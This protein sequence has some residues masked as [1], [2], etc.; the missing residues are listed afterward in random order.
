[1]APESSVPEA[2]RYSTFCIQKVSNTNEVPGVSLADLSDFCAMI[3]ICLDSMFIFPRTS[4]FQSAKNSLPRQSFH[5]YG[6]DDQG[7]MDF[8]RRLRLTLESERTAM[9]LEDKL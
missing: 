9:E 5:C 4:V 8:L 3:R 2:V 1:M 7:H 6:Q